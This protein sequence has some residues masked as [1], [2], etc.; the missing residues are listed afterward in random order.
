[1]N[2][3]YKPG[4][5][6]LAFLCGKARGQEKKEGRRIVFISVLSMRADA[7]EVI[8]SQPFDNEEIVTSPV[9]RVESDW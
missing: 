4:P 9:G 5:A 7:I 8:I 3:E 1:M 2:L 6:A